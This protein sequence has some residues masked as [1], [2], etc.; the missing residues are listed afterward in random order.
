MYFVL[1]VSFL[2]IKEIK[3]I[4]DMFVVLEWGCCGFFMFFFD[5][6]S[7]DLVFKI[8]GL[9]DVVKMFDFFVMVLLSE[10]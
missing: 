1:Y 2:Y 4:V 5:K 8:L 6:M 10:G 3:D 9:V 7:K